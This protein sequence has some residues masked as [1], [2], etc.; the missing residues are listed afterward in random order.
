[1]AVSKGKHVG[2]SRT[3]YSQYSK[4]PPDRGSEDP[5]NLPSKALAIQ[6]VTNPRS[7]TDDLEARR[8]ATRR[9]KQA[10][11]E[12]SSD[13]DKLLADLD[14]SGNNVETAEEIIEQTSPDD[15]DADDERA[16][17]AEEARQQRLRKAREHLE[18]TLAKRDVE[19][20]SK[21]V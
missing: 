5:E 14:M 4:N 1:M 20:R 10:F 11:V 9:E 21:N 19:R 17:V 8:E 16:R 2:S 13:L 12:A 7:Y 3:D 6:I 15:L 18:A